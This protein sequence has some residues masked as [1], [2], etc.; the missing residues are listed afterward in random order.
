MDISK[1]V[2][3]V[4]REMIGTSIDRVFVTDLETFLKKCLEKIEAEKLKG[5]GSELDQVV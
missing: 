2:N 4:D 1:I 3:E 5:G